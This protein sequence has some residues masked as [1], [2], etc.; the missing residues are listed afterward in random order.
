MHDLFG[1]SFGTANLLKLLG[2]VIRSLDWLDDA[3]RPDPAGTELLVQIED[4]TYAVSV[5][6]DMAVAGRR[7]HGPAR[8]ICL[9]PG[10]MVHL[11]M[12]W[13]SVAGVT[14]E[15][16]ECVENLQSRLRDVAQEKKNEPN[17]FGEVLLGE[18][19]WYEVSYKTLKLY[20]ETLQVLGCAIDLIHKEGSQ[21]DSGP[22]SE[23]T[24]LSSKLQ[25]QLKILGPKLDNDEVL[26]TNEVCSASYMRILWPWLILLRSYA[27]LSS[28]QR[29]CPFTCRPR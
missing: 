21:D 28:A 7:K 22:S 20:T 17:V 29:L 11:Q 4:L 24:D 23:V 27:E 16:S 26:S 3:E 10:I 15:C 13:G 18:T 8:S 14:Q 25:Y 2:S 19:G 9:L 5:L 6:D 1:T 12:L